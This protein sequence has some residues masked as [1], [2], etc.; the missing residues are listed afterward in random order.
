MHHHC[1]I[2]M[3]VQSAFLLATQM[4]ATLCTKHSCKLAA[5]SWACDALVQNASGAHL[6]A[7]IFVG[8]LCKLVSAELH[9]C[10]SCLTKFFTCQTDYNSRKWS[11]VEQSEIAEHVLQSGH[12]AWIALNPDTASVQI[13][14]TDVHS[15]RKDCQPCDTKFLAS[16]VDNSELSWL[17]H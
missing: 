14:H 15:L 13:I 9:S 8:Q 1:C 16:N 17:Y 10:V 7:A 2:R 6:A 5:N 11:P 4:V 3:S 12:D